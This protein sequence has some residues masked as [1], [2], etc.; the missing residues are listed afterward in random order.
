MPYQ[1]SCGVPR[2]LFVVLVVLSYLPVCGC[3][4]PNNGP[5]RIPLRGSVT[6]NAEPAEMLVL[7]IVPAKG[8]DGPAANIQIN[9]GRYAF[10]AENGPGPGPHEVTLTYYP[11]PSGGPAGEGAPKG[12]DKQT[13]WKFEIDIPST[14]PY[15]ENFNL[16]D[17]PST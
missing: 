12:V 15:E 5:K 10:T 16:D 2:P 4:G 8:N 13:S 14:A 11:P 7:N 6:L 1:A 17:V 3:G 9:H